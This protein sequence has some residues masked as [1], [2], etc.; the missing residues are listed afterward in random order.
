M[1]WKPT[2][3]SPSISFNPYNILSVSGKSFMDDP[4][5]FYQPLIKK[6]QYFK[7]EFLVI[8][9]DLKNINAN[10]KKQIFKLL[11]TA[12]ENPNIRT[13]KII[14][15]SEPSNE[16]GYDLGKE[17]EKLIGIPFEYLQYA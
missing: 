11:V 3:D 8:E 6:I 16:E 13:L 17:L 1:E 12:K 7:N 4:Y 15:A 14:W 10:S 5:S 9:I 2:Y